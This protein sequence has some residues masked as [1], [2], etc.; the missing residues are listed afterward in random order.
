MRRDEVIA[1]VLP[2]FLPKHRLNNADNVLSDF[3]S[4]IRIG[5]VVRGNGS[6][7]YLVNDQIKMLG[8][9]IHE[10]HEAAVANLARLPSGAISIAKVPSGAEGWLHATEDNF[11]AA[12]ILLPAA[13]R[14]FVQELG[15]PFLLA[16][17][18]RDDCFCWSQQQSAERQQKNIRE[19]LQ[20]FLAE[21]YNLTP[22]ILLFSDG[23]FS[24]YLEQATEPQAAPNGGPA[25]P[26]GSS[27]VREEAARDYHR[28]LGA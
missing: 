15:E 24:L 28:K 26:L 25:M 9:S 22:D 20:R 21:E 11:A 17:S 13:Q 6:Y 19:A 8:L 23:K 16:L 27:E 2:Q 10:L 4:R 1:R 5:Y 14:E 12:R 3:P 7:A 18:H